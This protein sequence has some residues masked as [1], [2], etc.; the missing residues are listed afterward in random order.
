MEYK[1][2]TAPKLRFLLSDG[3]G[4]TIGNIVIQLAKQD[5][6]EFTGAGAITEVGNGL[7][8]YQASAT[9]TDQVGMLSLMPVVS[10][11]ADTPMA[12]EMV[13]HT[14]AEVMTAIGN[15]TAPDNVGILN[16][17]AALNDYDGSDTAGVVTLLTRLTA[18]RAGYLDE[19]AGLDVQA[20]AAAALTAYD[21]PTRAEATADK[22]EIIERGNLAWITGGFPASAVAAL[23][24]A[25]QVL[26]AELYSPGAAPEVVLPAVPD[27][28]DKCVVFID[29]EDP[30]GVSEAGWSITFKLQGDLPQ[31]TMSG[32]IVWNRDVIAES[33]ADGRIQVELERGL[34]FQMKASRF[35]GRDGEVIT[36]P[37]AA[38]FNFNDTLA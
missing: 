30:A 16:A 25:D 6:T 27:D 29:A 10:G 28:P 26:L 15:L 36:V 33:G 34:S 35:F 22:A 5:G 11:T 9:D 12:F 23:E 17:I 18:A 37:D 3:A 2:G 13:S 31:K 19:L 38:T 4:V 7:Y 1:A 14:R 32:K 24:G 21:P 8:D 20:S